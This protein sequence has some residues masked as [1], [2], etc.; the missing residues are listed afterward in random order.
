MGK[1]VLAIIWTISLIADIVSALCGNAPTWTLVFCPLSV[2]VINYW[3]EF[4][5]EKLES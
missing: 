5:I 3:M 4:I 2:L 1:L